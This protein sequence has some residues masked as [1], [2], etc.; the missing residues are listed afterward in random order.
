MSCSLVCMSL[1]YV[2]DQR[3]PCSHPPF[4][5]QRN[6]VSTKVGNL[7]YVYSTYNSTNAILQAL[8]SRV[9]S[10]LPEQTSLEHPATLPKGSLTSDILNSPFS[11]LGM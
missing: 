8:N 10:E 1:Q 11:S 2:P 6:K 9:S 4:W 5:L 3:A 7:T